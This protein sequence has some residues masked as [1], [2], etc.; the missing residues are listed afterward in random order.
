MK[1]LNEGSK[2]WEFALGGAVII[3]VAYAGVHNFIYPRTEADASVAGISKRMDNIEDTQE[4]DRESLNRN[5]SEMRQDVKDIY[6]LL[7]RMKR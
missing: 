7:L 2:F 4:K 5:L 6:K 1:I 3:V